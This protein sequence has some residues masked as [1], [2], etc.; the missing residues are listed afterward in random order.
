MN[1]GPCLRHPLLVILDRDVDLISPLQHSSH[2]QV[3]FGA[4][5]DVAAGERPAALQ[6]QPRLHPELHVVLSRQEQ[7]RLLERIRL[8]ALRSRLDRRCALPRSHRSEQVSH[9]GHREASGVRPQ[10]DERLGARRPSDEWVSAPGFPA[11]LLKSAVETLPELLE[12][13]KELE[14]HTTIMKGARCN[15]M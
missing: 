14:K 2:Y 5:F 6:E 12:Q 15:R 7:R 13:K 10:H 9:G 11:D 1:K 8:F 4:S 3:L